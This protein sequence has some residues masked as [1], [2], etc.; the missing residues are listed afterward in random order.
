MIWQSRFPTMCTVTFLARKNGFV[1]GMNRDE[2]KSRVKSLPPA[3]HF[4]DKRQ[5]LY[6]FEPGGGA[7]VGVNDVGLGC[8][9]VNWYAIPTRVEGFIESRGRMIPA[10][11]ACNSRQEWEKRFATMPL[12]KTNPFRLIGIFS[13]S[14]ELLE[15]RWNLRDVS[16]LKHPWSPGIWISSGHDEPGAQKIR[17]E[18]FNAAQKENDAGQLIWLR[19][20]HA[21]HLPDQGPYSICMHRTDATTVSYTEMVVTPKKIQL[22]HTTGSPC[23]KNRP[24]CSELTMNHLRSI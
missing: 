14:R 22:R 3:L 10:M 9:I 13:A 12:Q 6:P 1:L 20:F 8:A 11:L 21:S 17:S 24:I 19:R 5:A 7:W 2:Q 4:L 15:W 23:E 18:T 16:I